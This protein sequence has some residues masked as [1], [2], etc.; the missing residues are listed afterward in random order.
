M[1][2][3]TCF[4]LAVVVCLIIF[5]IFHVRSAENTVKLSI[6]GLRV[7]AGASF[8]VNERLLPGNPELPGTIVLTYSYKGK[9]NP[10]TWVGKPI[11]IYTKSLGTIHT[12]VQSASNS[13]LITATKAY[14]GKATY[15]ANAK[16]HARI[17][18]KH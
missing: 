5:L 13:T 9:H 12:H 18:L 10:K 1:K 3:Q 8:A 7:V 15:A 14:A 17:T 6:T 16:D 2:G 11:T 4:L